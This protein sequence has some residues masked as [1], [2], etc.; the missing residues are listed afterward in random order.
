MISDRPPRAGVDPGRDV[1]ICW[2][3][4]RRGGATYRSVRRRPLGAVVPRSGVIYDRGDG[5]L[6]T[7]LEGASTMGLRVVS[8]VVVAFVVI[9]A[10]CGGSSK[11]KS[12]SPTSAATA[13]ATT[14][15]ATT[16][17]TT[18]SVVPTTTSAAPKFASSKNCAQLVALGARVAK[19]LQP[20]PGNAEASIANEA[21]VLK[22]LAGAAPSQIRGDFETFASAFSAYV[23]AF[24]KVGI[25]PG[26]VP[27][28]AQLAQMETAAKA[29]STPK[30]QA[31]EQHLSAWARKNCVG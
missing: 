5:S 14:G 23:Q 16:K 27:T 4:D 8:V 13:T 12:A 10:G 1:A 21:K 30:L 28:A 9:A 22:A 26:K 24:A 7:A 20:T 11:K 31:A 19:A 15:A 18:T 29:F 17:S 25:T 2:N 3:R 6:T